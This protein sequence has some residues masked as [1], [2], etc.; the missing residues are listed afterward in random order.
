MFSCRK[1]SSYKRPEVPQVSSQITNNN[2]MFCGL[3]RSAYDKRRLAES[4]THGPPTLMTQR[5]TPHF[6]P[7]S[8]YKTYPDRPT[9]R[10]CN[11]WCLMTRR[12]HL[13]PHCKVRSSLLHSSCFAISES[14]SSKFA[15]SKFV[16][17]Q[18]KRRPSTHSIFD[19]SQCIRSHYAVTA[20]VPLSS[21]LH[22]PFRFS[23]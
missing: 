12:S 14:V 23:T 9:T 5:L 16:S 6:E 1:R 18:L 19:V 15:V 13:P 8:H 10:I 4:G 7:L 3:C 20:F 22:S 11:F 21:V 17:S 2:C